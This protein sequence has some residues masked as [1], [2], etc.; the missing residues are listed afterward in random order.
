MIRVKNS[1]YQ[2]KLIYYLHIDTRKFSVKLLGTNG[3]NDCRKYLHIKYGLVTSNR[4][5]MS[6]FL[7]L[8]Y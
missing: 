6:K 8:F 2:S 1:D 3:T 7:T 4:Q 5:K